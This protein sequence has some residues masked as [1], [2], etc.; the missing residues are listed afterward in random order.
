[1]TEHYNVFKRE[2]YQWAIYGK[3]KILNKERK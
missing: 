3:L 1:M 2:G